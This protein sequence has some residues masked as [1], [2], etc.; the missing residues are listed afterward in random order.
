MP[1]L[2][3]FNLPYGPTRHCVAL[4]WGCVVGFSGDEAV[5]QPWM[6][7]KILCAY[8]NKPNV[9]EGRL[10]YGSGGQTPPPDRD[11]VIRTIGTQKARSQVQT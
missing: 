6:G 2:E 1:A 3:A 11:F 5:Y 4:N 9:E 7:C 8:Y 10:L